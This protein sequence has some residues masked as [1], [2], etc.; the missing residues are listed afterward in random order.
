LRPNAAASSPVT[1][2]ITG[3]TGV[4][5]RAIARAAARA[6]H[7]VRIGSRSPRGDGTPAGHEWARMDLLTGAGVP[8][9]VNGADAV[10]HAASDPRR[11]H[12]VDVGGTRLVVEAARAG[13]A[14]HVLYVSIVGI[15]RIPIPYFRDKLAAE[16]IVAAGLPGAHSIVRA[17]QFHS[18]VDMQLRRA[19]R[20]PVV[21][22]LPTRFQLQSAA[23]A[24]AADYVL[25]CAAEGP[26]GRRPDFGG[27][28]VLTL[29]EAAAAWKAAR[30]VRRAILPLPVP[31]KVGAA[32]RAGASTVPDGVRGTVRWSDWLRESAS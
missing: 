26:G 28:E 29:G 19:A 24:D 10:I 8:E 12:A 30:G 16:E 25:R 5:G 11:S 7:V 21:M 13:G 18:F 14:P 3:G 15:D 32:F 27:P 6:G 4:L 31:G 9:A 20:F 17:T 23:P 1:I 22:P 2:L